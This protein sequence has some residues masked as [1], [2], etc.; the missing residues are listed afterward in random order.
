MKMSEVLRLV[1]CGLVICGCGLL[2]FLA[3]RNFPREQCEKYPGFRLKP[4]GEDFSVFHEALEQ[5]EAFPRRK[6]L[7][8]LGSVFAAAA[9]ALAAY[10]AGT[11]PVLRQCM[12]LLAA[13]GLAGQEAE[14]L[15]E[16]NHPIPAAKAVFLKWLLLIAYC[17]CL[18]ANL[19]WRAAQ[20]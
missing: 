13:L 20:L 10:S 7:F 9:M 12:Y 14:L 8:G 19:G 4:K 3:Q 17:L 1:L 18:F 2:W 15:L 11:I 16:K 6:A 5:K